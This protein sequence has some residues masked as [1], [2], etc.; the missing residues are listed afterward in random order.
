MSYLEGLTNEDRIND[1]NALT[2]NA[3]YAMGISKTHGSISLG[4]KGSVIITKEITSLSYIPYAFGEQHI[5]RI[6]I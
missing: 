5:D 1:I 6:I 4:K 2:I 3:A